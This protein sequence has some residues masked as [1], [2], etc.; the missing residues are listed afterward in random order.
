MTDLCYDLHSHTTASDGS[1]T[2][3]ELVQRAQQQSVDVLAVTDHDVT[4][5]LEQAAQAAQDVDIGFIP[6]IEISVSW[7]RQ[8]VHILGLGI[9]AGFEDLQRG[10]SKLHEFRDWRGEEIASRLAKAGISGAL[11]GAKKFAGGRILSRT[12]F[13]HFLIEQGHAADMK[14]VFKNYLVPNKPGFV[15]GDWASLDDALNWIQGAGGIAVIAHPARYKMTA[16]RLRKLI[17]E[18]KELGGEGFEVVSG[19]HSLDEVNYMGRL[20]NQFELYASCGSDYHGPKTPYLEL[21]RLRPMPEGCTPVWQ[22]P[23]WPRL[24]T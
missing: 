17:G 14:T 12:H 22:S 2:P 11:E 6:G 5:G 13:A 16:T 23:N 4:A 21:G 15:S 18:F 8:T 3:T 7:N 24:N 10:L 19:T 20:A 9:D 1:L